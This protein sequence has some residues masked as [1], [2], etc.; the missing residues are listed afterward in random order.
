MSAMPDFRLSCTTLLGLDK[1]GILKPQSD[2]YYEVVLSAL[3]YPNGVGAIYRHAS[4][5]KMLENSGPLKRRLSDGQQFGEWG[6]PKTD[7]LTEQQAMARMYQVYEDRTCVHFKDV[8]IETKGLRDKNGREFIGIMGNVKPQGEL[9]RL[10]QESFENNL[11]NTA[12]SVRAITD[13][14]MMRGT[15]NIEKEFVDIIAWDAVNEPGLKPASKYQS[16]SLE[17][18]ADLNL[19]M[20]ITE[21]LLS[22]IISNAK[23]SSISVESNGMKMIHDT[24]AR[25]KHA[26]SSDVERM[27]ASRPRWMNL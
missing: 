13:N 24:Y 20:P 21:R 23:G 5:V 10:L 17:S 3:D 22:S 6:H 9:G 1:K 4:A 2:G 27:L 15:G 14:Y 8:W 16:P 18:F 7:G 19:D 11:C 25:L 12:F 26:S